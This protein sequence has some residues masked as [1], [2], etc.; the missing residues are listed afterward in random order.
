MMKAFKFRLYPTTIQA[1]QLN[2][3]IGSCR[4]VYNWALD[5]KIKTYEQTG[6]S[7][8]RFDLNKKIPVLKSSNKWLGK[9]NSQSLQGMTKQVESAFTRFFREKNGFPKFKSKKNPIHW[10]SVKDLFPS[11]VTLFESTF[12]FITQ[13][14]HL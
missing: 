7:I 4:F 12:S 8:S 9:V 1:T 5:Q 10:S 6:K 11:S 3:H 2:Q 14:I 13:T